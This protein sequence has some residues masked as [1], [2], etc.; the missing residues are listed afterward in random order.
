[1]EDGETRDD[2][3]LP[4]LVADAD[5][6]IL[7]LL[8]SY[9]ANRH[10]DIDVISHSIDAGDLAVLR[11]VGHNLK[12]SGAAYGLPPFSEFGAALEAAAKSGDFDALRDLRRKFRNMVMELDAA[13]VETER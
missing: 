4:G 11:R 7:Q 5:P 12:G 1:M 9:V 3:G 6:A 13:V 8:P 2:L 10:A